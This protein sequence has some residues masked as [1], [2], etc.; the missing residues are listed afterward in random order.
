MAFKL[1]LDLK[2]QTPMIHFQ[3]G[4]SGATLR[5]TELK[6][7]LDSFL[8]KK[9]ELKPEW[10]VKKE[11]EAL[12]YKIK[13]T[14]YGNKTVSQSAEIMCQSLSA[15]DSEAKKL[16]KKSKQEIHPLYFANMVSISGN[17]IE[18]N[19]KAIREGYKETVI[20]DKNIRVT[21]L[22]FIPELYELIKDNACEFFLTHN[23]GTRQSKGFGSFVVDQINNEKCDNDTNAVAELLKGYKY[24]YGVA[25][26]NSDYNAMLNHA[27]TVYSI[28]K[29]GINHT[30]W[31]SQ[32]DDY[33]YPKKYIKS[34][35]Q[36]EFLDENTCSEKAFIKS[37]LP[38]VQK[39]SANRKE[40]AECHE[41]SNAVFIRAML[42]LTDNFKYSKLREATITVYN[43]EENDF[44]IKR[45]KSPITIKIVDNRI[46]F[47]FDDSNLSL[48]AGKTFYLLKD[49]PHNFA[50]KS[51]EEKKNH[52]IS[53]GWKINTPVS[54]DVDKL[55]VGFVDYFNRE[56]KKLSAFSGRDDRH[57]N[58]ERLNLQVGGV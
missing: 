56:K 32:K 31:N 12:N 3:H 2:Q 20:Y 7:K 50:K 18:A 17:N 39:I 33:D 46:Y 24:F 53:E 22:C 15:Q 36:R 52:I 23:F 47:I 13:I 5:A 1:T 21:I 45:F 57:G 43:L 41:G 49:E 34:F 10:R 4:Q 11:T 27:F 54:I 40:N 44:G 9:A 26:K 30:F 28:L 48:I 42:G 16:S 14:P 51:Y 55:I 38:P 25:E 58:S 19:K 8:A 37:K 6:P 29:G 35:I